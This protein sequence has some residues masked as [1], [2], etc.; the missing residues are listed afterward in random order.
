MHEVILLASE[1]AFHGF[2]WDACKHAVCVETEPGN[3]DVE[4]FNRRFCQ[5][6]VGLAPVEKDSIRFGSLSCGHTN[7]GLRAI[8]AGMPSECA[9]LSEG[10]QFSLHK[11]ALRDTEYAKAV[12]TGLRWKV[13]RW[14]VRRDFPRVLGIIQVSDTPH[15][16]ETATTH[17]AGG[18]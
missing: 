18:G 1:I 15:I 7:M 4:D 14:T 2:S 12:T 6:A 16:S 3:T 13:L 9:L 8:A 10:G 11:L 17:T 5:D